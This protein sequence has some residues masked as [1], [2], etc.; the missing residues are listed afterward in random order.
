MDDSLFYTTPYECVW[1]VYC[2]SLLHNLVVVERTQETALIV[3]SYNE[4]THNVS[5]QYISKRSEREIWSL[6]N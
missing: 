1:K 4:L 5:G 3:Y 6:A 2:D